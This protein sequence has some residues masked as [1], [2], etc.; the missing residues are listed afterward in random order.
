MALI[1]TVVALWTRLPLACALAYYWGLT[2]TTQ[3]LLTPWLNRDFPDPKYLAFWAMH[4]LI[5]WAAV[6][7][8]WGLRVRPSWR[9]YRFTV[10]LT[11][12]WMVAVYLINVAVGTNYGFVNAKPSTGSVLDVLPGWPWYVLIEIAVVAVVWAA[13]TWPWTRSG[14]PRREAAGRD[15]SPALDT[16]PDQ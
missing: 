14:E 10:A 7:L 2:L 9:G 12:V 6:Y 11:L 1:A 4:L 15:R 8:T 13:M 5:V 16:Q 3:A